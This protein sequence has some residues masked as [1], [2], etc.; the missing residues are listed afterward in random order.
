[1]LRLRDGVLPSQGEAPPAWRSLLERDPSVVVLHRKGKIEQEPL[2]TNHSIFYLVNIS[3][4]C[5]KC[6]CISEIS[7][8]C[9]MKSGRCRCPPP[10]KGQ[11]ELAS[12]K[13]EAGFLQ[14]E[15]QQMATHAA[16]ASQMCAAM[17]LASPRAGWANMGTLLHAL[18]NTASAGGRPELYELLE[19]R[20][21]SLCLISA[22]FTCRH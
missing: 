12:K 14:N 2:E 17:D 13:L 11:G 5:V 3:V 4:G 16:M 1:M 22:W 9:S 18:S 19:V 20:I 10:P 8:T 6:A 7:M 21:N 15:L